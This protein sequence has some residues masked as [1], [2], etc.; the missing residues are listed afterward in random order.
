MDVINFIIFHTQMEMYSTKAFP[1]KLGCSLW[2]TKVCHSQPRLP[3]GINTFPQAVSILEF[4]KLRITL[5]PNRA[6]KDA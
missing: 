3:V 4:K 6:N 5:H 2:R 1:A